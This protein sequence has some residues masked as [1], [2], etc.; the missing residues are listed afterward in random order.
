M[1]ATLYLRYS[2]AKQDGGT[3]IE[4]QES[5]CRSFCAR[6]G[7][8]VVDVVKDEAVSANKTSAARVIDLLEYVEKNKSKFGLLVVYKLD[9]F[10]RSQEQH[11]WLRKELLKR[12]II[13]R[14]ATEKIGESG[15]EKLIEGVLAAVNEYDNDI[16]TERTKLGMVRRLEEGLWP[17]N[18]CYGYVLPKRAETRLSVSVIDEICAGNIRDI[19]KMYSTGMYTYQAIAKELNQRQVQNYKGT[20]LK[21]YPQV[22]QKI[23]TNVFYIGL[24]QS[25][26]DNEI[27]QGKHEP[28]IDSSL[29]QKCQDVT[30][31]KTRKT[32]R[33][34]I[35]EDFPLR[36]FV[37]APCDHL[38]TAAFS[39]NKIGKLY[40]YYFSLCKCKSGNHRDIKIHSKFLDLLDEIEPPHE[41]VD[42]Y[43]ELFIENVR[44]SYERRETKKAEL[45]IQQEKIK[46]QEQTLLDLRLD[47]EIDATTFKERKNEYI[48]QLLNIQ[49]Q[50]DELEQK[51]TNWDE[52]KR[53]GE[54]FLTNIRPRWEKLPVEEKQIY[55]C[56]IFPKKLNWGGENYRTP[57]LLE[58]LQDIHNLSSYSV[59]PEGIEPSLPG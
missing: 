19:F 58:V 31:A 50:V 47:G 5:M 13:L 3:T 20:L 33:K 52:V 25:S 56:S 53:F 38:M 39:R 10:A 44:T 51:R 26:I 24:T 14:S 17:W 57:V 6:E 4:V 7:H 27:R 28:L 30:E 37:L 16:R 54:S 1:K 2:D 29:W 9:R 15:S 12:N 35:S 59:T 21:F 46:Q 36:G 43:M 45:L 40:G 18:P 11:H 8:E 23:L 42:L 22:I 49:Q 55:Q 34:R 48:R 32:I 41:S